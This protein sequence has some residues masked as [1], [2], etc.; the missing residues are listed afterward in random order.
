MNFRSDSGYALPSV[1]LISLLIT[2]IILSLL[3]I[4]YFSAKGTNRILE[5]KKL[6]LACFSAVQMVLADSSFLTTDSL[7]IESNSIEVSLQIRNYGFYKEI[8]TKANGLNDSINLRYTIGLA[9]SRE[10]LFNYAIVFTRPNLR[11]TVAGDTKIKGNILS[12]TDRITI[13]NI[14][15]LHQAS[16]NYLEGAIKVDKKLKAQIIPDSLFDNIK[17]LG[18]SGSQFF[19]NQADY[20]LDEFSFETILP[21]VNNYMEMNLIVNGK[22]KTSDQRSRNIRAPGIIEFS[23]GTVSKERLE[24]FSDSLIVINPN[25]LVENALLYCDGPIIVKG[26]S[27]FKNVQLFSR[28]SIFINKSQFDYPSTVCL[29]I[30][31][32]QNEKKDNALVIEGSVING[33]VILMTKSSGFI[34]N[35]TKIKIDKSSKVQGLVYCENNLE[36]M[37]EVIGTVITYNLWYYKEPSEYL[38]WLI[39]TKVDRNNLDDWFLLP[40]VFENNG[41]LQILRE[42]WIY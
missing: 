21:E 19:H 36:L 14:F 9:P 17:N 13:G 16:E 3:A 7:L 37:G 22:I 1:L 30:D 38:N 34:S 20:L 2:S 41:R 10:D 12:T 28:D 29:N 4:L 5:K 35:R 39:N 33:N 6:K 15:G 32:S 42:E 31:D 18:L 8:T 24:L 27:H 23:K 26:K 11:A 40:T 25:C